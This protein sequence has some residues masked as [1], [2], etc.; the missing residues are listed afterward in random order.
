MTRSLAFRTRTNRRYW[1]HWIAD[2]SNYVPPVYQ[3]LTDE[4]WDVLDAWFDDTEKRDLIGECQVPLISIIQ[5]LLMGSCLRAVV[6]AGHYTGYST[7]LMGFML[8]RMG[9][10]HGL[11]TIDIDPMVSD[12]TREWVARAG[13]SEHV[14]VVCSD[15]A[16]PDMP[17]RAKA[18]LGTD[19]QLVLIDSSHIYSHTLRE[20]DLW[21]P[22]LVP[23]GILLC[24]DSTVFAE[25]FDRTKEGGVRRALAEWL[26]RNPGV[27]ALNLRNGAT[28]NLTGEVYKDACGVC[29]IQGAPNAKNAAAELLTRATA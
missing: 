1:W 7:L 5:G 23:G 16:A 21:Y 11:F 26:A 29:M 25:Q 6:Q 10:K 24:H 22:R 18:Y 9:F 14:E 13:L 3:F 28:P 12:Y 20:L 2:N 15:S 27:N 4:E 19:P 8:R 17:E